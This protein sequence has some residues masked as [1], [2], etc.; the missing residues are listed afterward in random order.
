MTTL[1]LLEN[2]VLEVP[3]KQQQ[4]G[5][6]SFTDT[7]NQVLE[8]NYTAGSVVV[9]CSNF[10]QDTTFLGGKLGKQQNVP[11]KDKQGI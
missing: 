6:S 9:L 7:W 10:L 1:P 2:N 5:K 11:K 4:R 8:E 3:G